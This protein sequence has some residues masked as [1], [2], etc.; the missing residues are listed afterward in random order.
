MTTSKKLCSLLSDIVMLFLIDDA[1]SFSTSYYNL[2]KHR[3][4]ASTS[5]SCSFQETHN[6]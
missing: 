5:S 4:E 1:A 2:G 3:D 6:E